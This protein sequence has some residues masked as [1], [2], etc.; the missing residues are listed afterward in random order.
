MKIK[1]IMSFIALLLAS[2][3]CAIER[4]NKQ[5]GKK[6]TKTIVV[7]DFTEI[8]IA[9]GFN[10]YFTQANNTS[11]KIRGH[12]KALKNV[13]IVS[14]GKTLTIGTKKSWKFLSFYDSDIDVY[15]TSPNLRSVSIAGS[16]EFKSSTKIDTDRMYISVAGNGEVDIQDII[17]DN[18]K[19][20]IAGSGEIDIKRITTQNAELSIAGSGDIDIENAVIDNVACEIAGSGNIELKGNIRH[21]TQEIAGSGSVNINQ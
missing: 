15:V 21:H 6:T 7:N 4:D 1:I 11:V 18:L 9:G 16:G 13:N 5:A 3:S 2:C 19:G 8:Q 12:E 14:N 10:V 17:C 20:E